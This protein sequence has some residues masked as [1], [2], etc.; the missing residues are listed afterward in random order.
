L[1][2][3]PLAL[4]HGTIIAEEKEGDQAG[5]GNGTG[6]EKGQLVSTRLRLTR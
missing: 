3:L 2:R 6:E 5:A 4:S 1:L